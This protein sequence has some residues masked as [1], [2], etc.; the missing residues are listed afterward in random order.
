MD[1]SDLSGAQSAILEQA[2]LSAFDKATLDRLLQHNDR[3]P[4]DNVVAPGPWKN[5]V[6]DLV[7][8]TQREGWTE[9]LLTIIREGNPDNP[10]IKNLVADLNLVDIAPKNRTALVANSLE[11]TVKERAGFADFNA[12]L[13]K[14]AGLKRKVCRIEDESV[15]GKALGTGFLVAPDLVMTNYHVVEAYIKGADVSKLGCR[16]DYALE[17]AD[18]KTGTVQA[19]AAGEAWLVD[20]SPYSASDLKDGSGTPKTSELDYALL[21]LKQAV[22]DQPKA[23]GGKRG[24]IAVSTFPALPEATDIVFIVQHPKGEPLKMAVGTVLTRNAN[25]T[26][27]RYDTNTEPG[28]SGSPCFDAKLDLVALHHAGDP[29]MA[30]LARF[31][32]GVPVQQIVNL[33]RTRPA[34][35]LFWE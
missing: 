33:L 7:Q 3:E 31:N 4:I 23:E 25:D 17:N 9:K 35:P 18:V 32:E 29:D 5:Q 30:Q 13:D 24:W 21:R 20:H 12:R 6:F 8:L 27:I 34:V 1:P 14:L 28:S 22:G 11:R 16:F 10:R 2:I 15:A 26:R 19:L